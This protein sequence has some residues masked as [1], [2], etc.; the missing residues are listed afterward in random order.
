MKC[1]R[2]SGN[3]TKAQQARFDAIRYIGHTACRHTCLM[4]DDLRAEFWEMAGQNR[5]VA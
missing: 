5:R 1:G 3:R 2:S 4:L